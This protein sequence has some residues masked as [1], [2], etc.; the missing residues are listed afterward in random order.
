MDALPAAKK[1][2]DALENAL[3]AS[4][5]WTPDGQVIKWK[6][7]YLKG[8]DGRKLHVRSPHSAL[9][10]LLQSAGAIICKM[11]ICETV[12]ILEEEHGLKQGNS[13]Q[14]DFMLCAWVHDEGQYVFRD[15]LK[16]SLLEAASQK[17]MRN[18]GEFFNFNC[19]LDTESKTGKTWADCH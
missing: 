13:A 15:N 19:L 17:A 4:S 18:C 11:W 14:D 1:L 12:R 10:I 16:A 8:L 5:K 7:K 2:K 6:R 9:N 3:I